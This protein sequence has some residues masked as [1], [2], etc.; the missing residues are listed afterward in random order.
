MATETKRYEITSAAG[1]RVAGRAVHVGDLLDLTENEA[2]FE[3][4]AGTIA[5]EGQVPPV[6]PPPPILP[7]DALSVTRNGLARSSLVSDLVALLL[8]AEEG[9]LLNVLDRRILMLAT[10]PGSGDIPQGTVRV[11]KNTTS[12]RL[13]LWANDGGTM[14]DLLTLATA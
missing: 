12:G 9:A 7:S 1:G 3:L 13:S 6:T 10:N 8:Q 2:R 4:L 11:T 14:V 5:L